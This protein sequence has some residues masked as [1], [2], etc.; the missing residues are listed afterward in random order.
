MFAL[1]ITA[2]RKLNKYIGICGQVPSDYKDMAK[3]LVEQ[4]I[5]TLSLNPDTVVETWL[6]LAEELGK[7]AK[8]ER[9]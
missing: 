7:Q 2:C 8:Q 1:A 6:Y 3:W 9:N 4:G 5:E